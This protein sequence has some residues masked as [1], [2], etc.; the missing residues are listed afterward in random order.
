MITD[1]NIK[2]MHELADRIYTFVEKYA[3]VSTEYNGSNNKYTNMDVLSMLACAVCL[4]EGKKPK[5]CFSSWRCSGA[6]Q[7]QFSKEG[8]QEH[9]A[10]ISEIYKIKKLL[11]F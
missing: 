5:E 11:N 8:K 4:K 9:N 3:Q 2:V 7:P 1:A 10:I 6:Y